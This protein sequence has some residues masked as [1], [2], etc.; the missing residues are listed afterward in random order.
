MKEALK[1]EDPKSLEVSADKEKKCPLLS[2]AVWFNAGG[3]MWCPDVQFI[4]LQG[5]R[6]SNQ[7]N[8]NQ[9]DYVTLGEL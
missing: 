9:E 1:G 8:T 5:H 4:W 6:R 3:Q 2:G 7:T